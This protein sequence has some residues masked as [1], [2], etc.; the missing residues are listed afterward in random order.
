MYFG[1]EEKDE[2]DPFEVFGELETTDETAVHDEFG[3]VTDAAADAPTDESESDYTEI[4]RDEP[5]IRE[6]DSETTPRRVKT[7]FSWAGFAGGVAALVWIGGAVG[8]PISY[9]GLHS[10]MTMDPAMQAGLIA[11]A[12]GPALLFWLAASAAGEALKARRLAAELT[13]LAHENR[14]PFQADQSNVQR[15]TDT[16]KTEIETLNDAVATALDR[17]EQLEAVA[18]RNAALFNDAVSASRQSTEEMSNALKHERDA[19]ADMTTDMRDQTE[20]MANAV[21]RQVRL[22]REASKLVKTE[23]GA[24]EEALETHLSSF[25]QAATLIGERTAE[26]HQAADGAA[27]AST[28]LHSAVAEAKQAATLVRAE[29]ASMRESAVDTLAK[30]N[31]AARAARE[32]SEESQAAA[33]RHAASIEKRLAA[34]AST[35]NA[36]KAAPVVAQQRAIAERPVERVVERAVEREPVT[37]DITMLQAAASAAVA[38]GG[39]RG[40][41]H[42]LA[43]SVRAE[44][45]PKRMFKGFG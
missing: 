26:F 24:A 35:A 20:T 4:E 38:R 31:E 16:V 30:L 9:F 6:F 23:I 25:S 15:L 12:F 33:D 32:A 7:G 2:R 40:V 17:L 22:M 36:K 10:V 13:R 37:V 21:G 44:A 43:R 8:G 14:T 11:L 19:L 34:L 42:G 3:D 41:A 18:Q 39:S 1:N 5:A 27:H 28:E 29:A 45:E